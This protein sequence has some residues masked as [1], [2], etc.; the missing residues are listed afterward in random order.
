MKKIFLLAFTFLSSIAGA[1]FHGRPEEI[2]GYRPISDG[3]VFQVRSGGCTHMNDF[4]AETK[5]D[6]RTGAT[7]LILLRVRPDLCHPFLPMGERFKFSYAELGLT[8]GEDFIVKNEN[9]IVQGWIWKD[10]DL[11]HDLSHYR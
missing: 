7:E 9:G 3:I 5:R 6:Q 4:V 11:G 2:L 8:P 1:A 10:I